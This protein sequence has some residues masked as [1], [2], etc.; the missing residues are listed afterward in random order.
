MT[1]IELNSS[2]FVPFPGDI[3]MRSRG[4]QLRQKRETVYSFSYTALRFRVL[5]HY[6]SSE[7]HKG[8]NALIFSY[9]SVRILGS[10]E[11]SFPDLALLAIAHRCLPAGFSVHWFQAGKAVT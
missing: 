10:N 11:E 7:V 3:A 5:P 1:P 9:V 8:S 2:L 6:R 4:T